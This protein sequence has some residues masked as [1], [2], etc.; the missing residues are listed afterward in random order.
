MDLQ[1]H[2]LNLVNPWSMPLLLLQL[3]LNA[4]GDMPTGREGKRVVLDACVI[5]TL[6]RT[7]DTVP[8]CLTFERGLK[9][10]SSSS[11][12]AEHVVAGSVP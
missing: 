1:G 9:L 7:G 11:K 12:K 3:T 2:T 8:G 10:K 6:V 5:I 4:L